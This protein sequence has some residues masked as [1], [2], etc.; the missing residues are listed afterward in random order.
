MFL[1][2]GMSVA[3]ANDVT[4]WSRNEAIVQINV[5]NQVTVENTR[6]GAVAVETFYLVNENGENSQV[7]VA[8]IKT[9]MFEKEDALIAIDIASSFSM[10]PFNDLNFQSS[11]RSE[12]ANVPEVTYP[13]KFSS[14]I[15]IFDLD[16]GERT[17]TSKVSE[18]M[19]EIS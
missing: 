12:I 3:L 6:T 1:M 2:A 17:I 10:N 15:A 5:E 9:E 11:I 8:D 4:A 19:V 18:G 14:F 7:T 16:M 13:L